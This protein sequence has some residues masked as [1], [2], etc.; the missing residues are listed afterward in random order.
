M[1]I[2]KTWYLFPGRLLSTGSHRW[3]SDI[4]TLNGR[5]WENPLIA[6]LNS[7]ALTVS[8]CVDMKRIMP[9][10][11]E[12]VL[13]AEDQKILNSPDIN[14]NDVKKPNLLETKYATFFNAKRANINATIYCEIIWMVY[15]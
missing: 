13:S 5:Y 15:S 10:I 3:Q 14:G 9:N 2:R 11:Q 4:Q 7:R 12:D 6:W 8:S 1:H